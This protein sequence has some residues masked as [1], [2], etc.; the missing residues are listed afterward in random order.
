MRSR[1]GQCH[2]CSSSFRPCPLSCQ[3]LSYVRFGLI[4][5]KILASDVETHPLVQTKA[6]RGFIHEAYRY[7][8]LPQ[9]SRKKFSASMDAR[10]RTRR[11]RSSSWSPKTR[12]RAGGRGA[13]DWG[14]A[15]ASHLGRERSVSDSDEWEGHGG[16]DDVQGKC[17]GCV[18]VGGGGKGGGGGDPDPGPNPSSGPGPDSDLGVVA[19]RAGVSGKEYSNGRREGSLVSSDPSRG[20]VARETVNRSR[21]EV[22]DVLSTGGECGKHE[23]A[24]EADANPGS[25][26]RLW[27]VGLRAYAQV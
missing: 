17:T 12:G 13:L 2:P 10:A 20:G 21:K 27:G 16:T 11:P 6:T 23:P 22:D 24:T 18:D 5:A 9:D 14:L 15:P 25:T 19:E 7:Q 1:P 3:V 8:A 26:R 4:S